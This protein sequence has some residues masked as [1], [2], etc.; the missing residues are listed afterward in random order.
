MPLT[1]LEKALL[2][3]KGFGCHRCSRQQV[4]RARHAAPEVLRVAATNKDACREGWA[5]KPQL[6]RGQAS[7]I[8][9]GDI[10]L[11]LLESHVQLGEQLQVRILDLAVFLFEQKAQAPVLLV[12][13]TTG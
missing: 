10:L 11:H 4:G 5:E 3:K 12:G 6:P 9:L 2:A 13:T 1:S 7:P 8:D